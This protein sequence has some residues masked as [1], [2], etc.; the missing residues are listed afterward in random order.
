M[1]YYNGLKELIGNTPL[2]KLNNVG[3]GQGA[4]LFAKLELY[5]PL[6]SL[7]IAPANIWWSP[8]SVTGD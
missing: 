2:V 1:H 6:G 4:A 3:V 7:R 8:S 5:N